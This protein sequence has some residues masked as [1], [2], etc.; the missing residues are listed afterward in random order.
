M[1]KRSV[2]VGVTR[3]SEL[4]CQS[5]KPT[6]LIHIRDYRLFRMFSSVTGE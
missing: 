2:I 1:Q 4:R 5:V 6:Y 3:M